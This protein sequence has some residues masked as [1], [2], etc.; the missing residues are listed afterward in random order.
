M[1]KGIS[2]VVFLFFRYTRKYITNN[3]KIVVFV[4]IGGKRM[5]VG[6]QITRIGEYERG[7]CMGDFE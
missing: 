4:D 1:R 2:F 3:D 5:K 6:D 7:G